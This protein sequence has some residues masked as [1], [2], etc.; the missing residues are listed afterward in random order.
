M[1]FKDKLKE[2]R[3]Q[4]SITQEDLAKQIGISKS[5]IGMYE[6]GQREPNFETL[7][8]F[9]DYFNVTMDELLDRD[10]QTGYYTDPETADIANA[11]KEGDGMLRVLFDA[12][13]DLPPEKMKEAANYIQFLKAKQH[14]EDE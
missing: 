4:R 1:S 5:A 7:E 12:A 14:P 8:I 13:R 10:T 9:A 3:K 2:L 6:S 11:L